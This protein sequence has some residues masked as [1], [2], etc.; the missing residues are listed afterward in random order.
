MLKRLIIILIF[1]LSSIY[2]AY[3]WDCMTH[4]YIAKMAGL[5]IPEAACM[6]DI[7]RDDNYD[8]LAPFHYHDAAPNT[9]VTVDYIDKFKIT[10]LQLLHNGKNFKVYVP[11]PAGVLYWRIVDIYEKMKSLDKTKPD[12][13]LAYQYYLATIAHFIGDLSQPLHN[14]PYGDNIA[15]D[16]KIYENEGN[17]NRENHIKFDEAF[18]EYLKNDSDINKKIMN[19]VKEINL[20][21]TE[22]LKRE[23]AK[24]ANSALEIANKCYIENRIPNEE[25]LI[26]QVASSISLLKAVVK[27]T[28]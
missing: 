28:N 2:P 7:T 13:K 5:N 12:N 27:S 23:I 16:G 18:S 11:R 26:K 3:A 21:S 20:E 9:V 19:A 15:S 14:F 24:I 4:A 17:F 8:L 10:E 1:L 25:E 6:P 22:D